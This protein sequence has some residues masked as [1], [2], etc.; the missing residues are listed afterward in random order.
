MVSDMIPLLASVQK[1][2]G[3]FLK[4]LTQL[5]GGTRFRRRRR[6][7]RRRQRLGLIGQPRGAGRGVRVL[8]HLLT[9]LIGSPTLTGAFL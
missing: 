8:R 1:S 3:L 9:L 7:V 6:R 2:G 5:R 4:W